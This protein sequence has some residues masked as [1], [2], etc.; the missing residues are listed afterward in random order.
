MLTGGALLGR[1]ATCATDTE[2]S[3]CG[4]P[5]W[6]TVGCPYL[7]RVRPAIRTSNGHTAPS[8]LGDVDVNR[9]DMTQEPST[10]PPKIRASLV[11][12]V[13]TPRCDCLHSAR[14]ALAAP[15]APTQSPPP[16]TPPPPAPPAP[17]HAAVE[18]RPRGATSTLLAHRDRHRPLSPPPGSTGPGG[19]PARSTGRAT[20]TC[21]RTNPVVSFGPTTKAHRH[22]P[23]EGRPRDAARPR[24]RQ[25]GEGR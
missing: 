20:T 9:G 3:G 13:P 8:I 16:P 14:T 1:H 25:R 15:T 7:R 11:P 23:G 2:R 21:L 24:G 19:P 17:P 6:N 5:A 12:P 18:C 10:L 4:S 22:R